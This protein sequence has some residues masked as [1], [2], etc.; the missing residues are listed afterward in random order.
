MKPLDGVDEDWEL[1]K[2]KLGRNGTPA[3]LSPE[4]GNIAR[5]I[6]ARCEGLP[7]GISVIARTMKGFR[8]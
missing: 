8:D 5:H 1:F 4:I 7:L 6:L 3:T 2:V